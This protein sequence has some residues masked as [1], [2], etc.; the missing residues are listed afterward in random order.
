MMNFKRL[1]VATAC[2]AAQADGF[3]VVPAHPY[4]QAMITVTTTQVNLRPC[5]AAELEACAYDLMKAATQEER[6]RKELGLELNMAVASTAAAA[7]AGVVG[8]CRKLFSSNS[9][10]MTVRP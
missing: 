3:A 8:W 6:T 5:Q 2:L 7:P 10:G 4:H 9:K 1:L